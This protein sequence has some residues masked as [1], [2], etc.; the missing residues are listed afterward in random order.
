MTSKKDWINQ[1]S[2]ITEFLSFMLLF[3]AV[4]GIYSYF[5]IVKS[6]ALIVYL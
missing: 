1:F 6:V 5:V 3:Y 2:H 4:N